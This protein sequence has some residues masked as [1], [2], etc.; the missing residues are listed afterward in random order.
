SGTSDFANLL[1]TQTVSTTSATFTGLSHG[2]TYYIRAT[3]TDGTTTSVPSNV[4]SS[5]QD[6][7]APTIVITSPTNGFTTT[8]GTLTLQGSATD[9]LSSIA[10][11]TVDGVTA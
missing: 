6:A 5:T 3:A 8:A 9:S 10:S 4:V 1:A 11:V 7:G 2:N